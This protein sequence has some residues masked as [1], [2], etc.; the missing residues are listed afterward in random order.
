MRVDRCFCA[1]YLSTALSG[2][3]LGCMC[4]STPM[5]SQ[6]A[7][8]SQSNA[9]FVGRVVEIWPA[10]EVLA[11]QQHLSR[12]QLRH[13][14]LQRWRGALSADEERYVRTSPEWGKIE[15][16]YAYMQRVRFAVSE[17][18]T[19]PPIL[20]I[21]TDISSCG[22][23]FD[24][25]G[26][27]LVNSFRDGPRYRTVACSRTAR[28]DSVDAVEDLK[29][30][31]AWKSGNPLAPRI[32]GRISSSDLRADIRVR[33]TKD[34]N[35]RLAHL[36]A[37]GGFSFE[38]LQKAQYRL[39]VQDARG[40]G[41]RVIDLSRLGCFEATPWFSVVWDIAGSPVLLET[42]SPPTPEI[43]DPP[44]LNPWRIQQ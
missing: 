8:L 15:F 10:R 39:E 2:S 35:E 4:F 30:L 1:F 19:G 33:L 7:A 44:L 12:P 42:K 43:P 3:V 41:G 22:Y 25:G 34:Q 23:R 40:T 18:F 28:V 11:S 31:R 14:I 24:P 20:E 9:V 32:Y 13:L 36:D 5:C 38:G 16:R 26:S 6:V 17:L 27:Y 21:Y 29:A 37:N